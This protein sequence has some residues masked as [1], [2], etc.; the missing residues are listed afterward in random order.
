MKSDFSTL[1]FCNVYKA[2]ELLFM[3][4]NESTQ[5]GDAVML[6]VSIVSKIIGPF[7][8]YDSI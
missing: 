3:E 4:I 1:L 2:S 8:V 7:K 5:V 6:W